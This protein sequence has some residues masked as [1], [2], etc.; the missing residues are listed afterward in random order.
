MELR[1]DPITRSWV[2]TG[3]EV[4]ESGP[5]PEPFCRFCPDSSA[6]AQV[7]SSVRGIDGIAW[8]ARSVVHPSPLYRIEGDPARRGD[9]IYDRMGSVGAHEVLVE[10]PRHDRHLWNS[11]DAEIEQFLVLAAQRIQDL[12]RDPRFKYISIFKNYGPNAGQEFEHP[13]RDRGVPS[14]AAYFSE[15]P[16]RVSELGILEDNQRGLS[17]APGNSSHPRG[18]GAIVHVQRGLL[19]AFDIGNGSEAAAGSENRAVVG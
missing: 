18:Q 1:K 2:I 5:R 6:P 10:N 15:Q 12:K 17:L 13:N 19:F 14:R 11:S 16:S 8:S 4:T 3:D 9:G 7:V